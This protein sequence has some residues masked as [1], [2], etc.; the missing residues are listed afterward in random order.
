MQK[1]SNRWGERK[2]RGGKPENQGTPP[3]ALARWWHPWEPSPQNPKTNLKPQST[4]KRGGHPRVS[5]G[6]VF[7]FWANGGP[8]GAARS[9]EPG[10]HGRG[11]SVR[12]RLGIIYFLADLV[13]PPFPQHFFPP[14]F[15]WPLVKFGPGPAPLHRRQTHQH[16]THKQHKATTSCRMYVA[17]EC[18]YFLFFLFP[19]RRTSSLVSKTH[20]GETMVQPRVP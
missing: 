9:T 16:P 19:F 10:G 12:V 18:C 7:V 17:I 14:V 3:Q 11:G 15:L 5:G 2:P 4:G 8:S 1:D 6:R 20:L 13:K